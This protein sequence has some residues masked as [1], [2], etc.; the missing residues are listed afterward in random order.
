MRILMLSEE[1]SLMTQHKPL[2]PVSSDSSLV[3]KTGR[4]R[5][6]WPYFINKVAPCRQACPIGIDI[7]AAFHLASKG[8]IDNALRSYLMENP[9]PGVCG[10][11]C[12]HPCDMD[13][14][15]ADFDGAINIRGFERFLGDN[16]D[17]VQPA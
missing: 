4:Q 7:P 12:Y 9:L 8:K 10:R 11:V 5:S 15:R 17:V 14:N 16:G 13:C 3:F 6:E 1:R 2:I